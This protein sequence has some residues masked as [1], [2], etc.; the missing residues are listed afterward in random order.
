M[1]LAVSAGYPVQKLVNAEEVEAYLRESGVGEVSEDEVCIVQREPNIS[2]SN[3]EP[4]QN[5]K[6]RARILKARA[7]I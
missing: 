6:A 3:S 1:H 2:A 4:K 7:T 5:V